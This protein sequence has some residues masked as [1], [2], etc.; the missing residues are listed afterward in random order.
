MEQFIED[1]F[2]NGVVLVDTSDLFTVGFVPAS[3]FTEHEYTAGFANVLDIA[4]LEVPAP[5]TMV[6]LL[7]GG[8][9][10]SNRRRR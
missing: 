2:T 3:G 10:A 1:S 5:G 4:G 6:L 8:C 7:L 9:I